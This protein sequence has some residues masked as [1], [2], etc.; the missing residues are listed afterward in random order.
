MKLPET[1]VP[2]SKHINV[3]I[4]TPKESGNKYTFDQWMKYYINYLA[5]AK[6]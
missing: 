2:D 5:K 1:F 4:K 3:I 6:S